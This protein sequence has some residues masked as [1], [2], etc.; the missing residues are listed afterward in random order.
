MKGNACLQPYF[1]VYERSVN[2]IRLEFF[3]DLG[4]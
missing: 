3:Y 1:Y 2:E 4:N